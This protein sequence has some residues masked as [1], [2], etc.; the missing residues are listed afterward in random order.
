MPR[1]KNRTSGDVAAAH[2]ANS[3]ICGRMSH[4][5]DG[6]AQI[7]I[8]TDIVAGQT[9]QIP[10]M[11]HHAVLVDILT[12][13]AQFEFPDPLDRSYEALRA[14]IKYVD[15]TLDPSLGGLTSPLHALVN[16]LS[17]TLKG[18]K[19]EM[20]RSPPRAKGPPKDQSFA[21]VQGVLAGA[22]ETLIRADMP[23]AQAA[24]F[25]ANEASRLRISARNGEPISQ[26]SII[27]WRHRQGGDLSANA[28]A[29]FKK[30]TTPRFSSLAD[31]K[32]YVRGSLHSL[33]RRGHGRPP[34]KSD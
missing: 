15:S 26:N 3:D 20:L 8:A 4:L 10:W 13:I 17:D 28:T 25:V 23:G 12:R 16:A 33:A 27:Q 2:A 29:A 22:L 32:V 18:G 31:A 9:S 6:Q 19:P 24:R 1:D 30:V 14:A 11:D 34:P 5:P 21:S 7:P